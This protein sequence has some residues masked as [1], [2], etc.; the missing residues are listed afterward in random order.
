MN[1]AFF[2]RQASHYVLCKEILAGLF[3]CFLFL[4]PTIA[5]LVLV[6]QTCKIWL[7]VGTYEKLQYF[8]RY[9]IFTNTIPQD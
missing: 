8:S 1:L 9:R 2:I 7:A 4:D 3:N 5:L 6:L